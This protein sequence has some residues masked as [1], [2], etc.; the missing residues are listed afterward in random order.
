[1]SILRSHR[2]LIILMTGLLVGSLLGLGCKGG[3]PKAKEAAQPLT[4]NWWRIE[5][6]K[7]NFDQIIKDYKTSQPNISV[8]IQTVRAEELENKLLEALAAGTGPD[9][10]SLPNSSLGGW[11]DKLSPLPASLKLPSVEI[12]GLFKKEAQWYFKT[13]STIKPQAL[14]DTFVDVVARDAIFDNKTYGL[15]ISL[16]TLLLFYNRD[17]LNNAQISTAPATWTEFKDATQKITVLDKSGF[18]VQHGAAVGE[19][20]NVPY[21]DDILSALMLQNGTPMTN[22][23]GTAATFNQAVKVGGQDFFPGADALRFY[24]DFANPSKETYTWSRDQSNAWQLFAAGKIGFVFAYWRD[25]ATL[26]TLSPK[27]NIGVANFPQIDAA[28]KPVY[29]ASYYLETVP[30]QSQHPNEAWNFIQYVTTKS[31]VADKYLT[32]AQKPTALRSLINKQLEDIDL[33]KP[34]KQLLTAKSWYHGSKSKIMREIFQNMI[35]QAAGG[36]DLKQAI[37]FAVNQVG[38]TLR[39]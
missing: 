25:L 5:G 21:S 11:L 9:I 26:R 15:P 18:F 29:Y 33:G 39:K 1:M 17:L 12:K 8:N 2:G 34:A 4:L 7:S 24:T 38:Q 35:R 32:S 13:S 37:D 36:V 16:D 30:K 14:T 10:V 22:N 27:I 20:D 31:E 3:D 19:A 23:T 28:D 6:E